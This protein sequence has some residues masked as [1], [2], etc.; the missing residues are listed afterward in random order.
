MISWQVTA[1]S[2]LTQEPLGAA[3]HAHHCLER[4][5]AEVPH[6][7]GA[8]RHADLDTAGKGRLPFQGHGH[9]PSPVPGFSSVGQQN[10]LR[11]IST[12]RIHMHFF[13]KTTG[14]LG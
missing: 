10:P 9:T 1:P 8:R 14:S 13:G 5:V 3:E 4:G 2:L 12:D 6:V 11:T 7:D